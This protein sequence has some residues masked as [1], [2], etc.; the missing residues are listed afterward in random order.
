MAIGIATEVWCG[1]F[2]R[3]V[4]LLWELDQYGEPSSK[5]VAR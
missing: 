1:S 5:V 2:V 3:S 4:A